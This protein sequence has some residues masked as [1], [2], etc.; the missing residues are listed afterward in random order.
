M[1]TGFF[2]G[3]TSNTGDNNKNLAVSYSVMSGTD[4]N[5]MNNAYE[6]Y[7][8]LKEDLSYAEARQL[9]LEKLNNE[10]TGVEKAELGVDGYTIFVTY[11]DGDFGGIDTFEPNESSSP[12]SGTSFSALNG[13]YN[14]VNNY[15]NEISFDTFAE[16]TKKITAGSKKVLIL[17]PCYYDYDTEPFEESVDYFKDHNWADEDIVMKVVDGRSWDAN[18]GN[19][20][21]DDFFDLS[22]YGIILYTGHGGVHCY[23]NFN[24]DNIYLQFCFITNDSYAVYPYLKTWKDDD[25]LMVLE[26]RT[27]YEGGKEIDWY[28]TAVR[29]DALREKLGTLPGSYMHLSTCFGAHFSKVFLDHGAKMFLGWTWKANG[30][31]ADGNMMNLNR[32]MLEDNCNLYGAYMDDT[33]IRSEDF[34]DNYFNIYSSGDSEAEAKNFYFPAWVDLTVTGIP[35]GTSYIKSSVYDS[36]HSLIGGVQDIV[37]YGASQI[38]CENLQAILAPATEEVTVEVKALSSIGSEL[39]SG[40]QNLAL[41][42]GSNSLQITLHPSYNSYRWCLCGGEDPN[43]TIDTDVSVEIY[44]NGIYVDSKVESPGHFFWFFNA[45]PGQTLRIDAADFPITNRSYFL[46]PIW[47]HSCSTDFKMQLTSYMDFGTCTEYPPPSMTIYYDH[48]FTIPEI[49]H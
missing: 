42:A 17:G 28:R 11:S 14:N 15:K 30:D 18:Y 10:T 34:F 6:E 33:I 46:G 1:G 47:L 36:S 4:I 13:G 39:S 31:Y 23:E 29:A 5:I 41:D 16:S 12:P 44:V 19:L 8:T 32:L 37:N 20:K 3:C 45:L 38:K 43:T 2:V 9:L 49:Y 35:S 48:N 26:E 27:K 24:E 7:D 25:K 40:E 21:P 22:D